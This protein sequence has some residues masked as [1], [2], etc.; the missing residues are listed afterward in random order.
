VKH[1]Y[2]DRRIM[3][4]QTLSRRHFLKLGAASIA[5]LGLSGGCERGVRPD[6]I[7]LA[8]GGGGA[9]G[10]AHILIFE[11]LEE[12]GIRPW[13]IAG[14]SIGAVMGALYAAGLSSG[15]IRTMIDEL[16]VSRDES[17]LESLFNERLTKWLE[18][19]DLRDSYGG[20]VSTRGFV[21]YL[22]ETMGKTRFNQLEIPLKIVATDFWNREQVVFRRGELGPAIAAS[23]AIPGVF[24]PVEHE[25]RVL[26]D[27]GLVNP[28]P[29]D[30][31]MDACDLTIAV[32]VQGRVIPRKGEAPTYF[33]TTFNSMQI[34]A[35]TLTRAQLDARPPD[36]YLK[37]DIQD[38]R[39]LDFYRF[40][41]IFRQ[42]Q[43]AKA[44]LKRELQR[45]LG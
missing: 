17:W 28:L 32:D 44:A 29:Y 45:R 42:T 9:R 14:T 10:L 30:V 12:L 13:R 21:D 26:V 27:G 15:Q 35:A 4:D 34:M 20:L 19:F 39:V 18:F 23:M 36:I 31:I 43:P 5:A 33:E 6:R 22:L 3:P 37:P 24:A 11:A 16:T 40:E 41:E 38:V 2:L 25:G 7:G 8:L 1:N